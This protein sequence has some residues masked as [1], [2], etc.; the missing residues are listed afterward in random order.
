M[1]SET[2]YK[3]WNAGILQ[4]GVWETIYMTV[5]STIISSVFV[6]VGEKKKRPF[7]NEDGSFEMRPSIDLGLTVDERIADGYYFSKTVRIIRHLIEHPELLEQ[8]ACTP[9]DL[10]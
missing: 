10:D 5:I 4:R 6:V 2:F 1:L 8:P 7:F 9:V 3:L